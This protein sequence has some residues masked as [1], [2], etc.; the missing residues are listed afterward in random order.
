MKEASA[1]VQAERVREATK[2]KSAEE[3]KEPKVEV[4]KVRCCG[5]DS[6]K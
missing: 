4:V 5:C 6:L 1:K 3:Q 2:A